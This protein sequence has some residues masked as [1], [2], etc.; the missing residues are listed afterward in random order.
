MRYTGGGQEESLIVRRFTDPTENGLKVGQ[1]L[2]LVQNL[3]RKLV[4]H[5][6]VE[7]R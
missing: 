6:V 3:N 5:A 2:L 7:F 4:I 1:K